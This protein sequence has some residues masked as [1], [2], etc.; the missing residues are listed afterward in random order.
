MQNK[1]IVIAA[2]L[3]LA[4]CME[5]GEPYSDGLY[6]LSVQ[7]VYPEGNSPRSGASV[8]IENIAG[9][10]SR[11][12]LTDASGRVSVLLPNGI[13]R[14]RLH[15]RE[16]NAVFNG[17]R[18]KVIVNGADVSVDIA[19]LRSEAG[20]LV[21]KELYCGGCPKDPEEGTYQSDQ[22][23]ILHNNDSETVYLDGLCLGTLSPYNSNSVNPWT[24]ADGKLPAFVPLIQAVWAFPGDGRRFPL[25]A[26]EDAVVCLRGAIDH[27]AQ[28]PLSVNLNR[29]NY[30]VCYNN[31]YFPNPAYH[32]VP[33][34]RISPDRYLEVVVKTGQANAYTV[35]INSPAFVIFRAQGVDIHDFAARPEN[36]LQVPGSTVDRVLAVPEAW[37][38]DGVEVFNGGSSDNRKR[39]G[40]SIDSGY[41]TLSE[42]FKGHSLMRKTDV[43]ATA[44]RGF[45]V[46]QDSNHSNEDFYERDTQ[47]LHP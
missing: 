31:V 34:D 26:G 11:S 35:S 28:Y 4:G 47:S 1:I 19:L 32:P 3:L 17:S 42:P 40:D 30:F 6:A 25:G 12:L 9:G 46:L 5:L 10:F 2:C 41:I 20:L 33:G 43:S 39:L 38:L 14:V 29:E 8:G 45:E 44:E 36:L 18:D 13:Y 22:Y 37:V 16:G 7:A 24:G 21:I 27:S 23:V 15:D